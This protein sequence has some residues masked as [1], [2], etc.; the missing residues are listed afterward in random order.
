MRS[1]QDTD[2]DPKFSLFR[3]WQLTAET[4]LRRDPCAN[5]DATGSE[6]NFFRQTPTGD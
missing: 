6:I 4:Y 1:C 3:I 2:I 5:A